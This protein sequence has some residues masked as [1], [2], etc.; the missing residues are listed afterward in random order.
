MLFADGTQSYESNLSVRRAQIRR[1]V[2]KPSSTVNA[3]NQSSVQHAQ[4][5]PHL[6]RNGISI[7]VEIFQI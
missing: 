6:E 3:R 2:F 7:T 5:S 1:P 4:F